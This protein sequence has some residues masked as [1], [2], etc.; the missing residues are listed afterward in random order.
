MYS[1]TSSNE[2]HSKVWLDLPSF[3]LDLEC[4]SHQNTYK[5][6]RQSTRQKSIKHTYIPVDK[7]FSA[8]QGVAGGRWGGGGWWGGVKLKN[9]L[10]S[11]S[12]PP[13]Q[14]HNMVNI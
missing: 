2:E 14:V 8:F 12:G 10:V 13:S 3:A 11:L 6:Q 1:K 5:L 9:I 4:P 7:D